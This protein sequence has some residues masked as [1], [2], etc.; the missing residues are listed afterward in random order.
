MCACSVQAV[1][2]CHVTSAFCAG[3]CRDAV[4]LQRMVGLILVVTVTSVDESKEHSD[5]HDVPVES[6]SAQ[7]CYL[8]GCKR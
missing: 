2:V 6:H 4:F 8:T 7:Q 5:A 1:R 3:G